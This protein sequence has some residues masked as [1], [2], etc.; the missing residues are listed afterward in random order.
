M[1]RSEFLAVAAATGA[2]RAYTALWRRGL[3]GRVRRPGFD[4]PR[5][6]VCA[7]DLRAAL[8]LRG[9]KTR[10]A[11][12]L[13]IPKQRVYDFLKG[14]TRLPDAELTLRL[15]HGLAEDRAGRDPSL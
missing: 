7:A 2:K 15:L 14:R 11:H 6:K 8:Q 9:A 4:T 5:W 3:G 10:L 1:E 13:G 12:Y